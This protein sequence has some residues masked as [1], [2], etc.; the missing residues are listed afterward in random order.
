MSHSRDDDAKAMW[1]TARL[2][3]EARWAEEGH[4]EYHDFQEVGACA[5][6]SI[7]GSLISIREALDALIER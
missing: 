4:G 7:A 3:L 1:E 6:V 2:S 5:L